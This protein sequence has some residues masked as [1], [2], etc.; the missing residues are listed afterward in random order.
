[1]VSYYWREIIEGCSVVSTSRTFQVHSEVFLL[2]YSEHVKGL[3]KDQIVKCQREWHQSKEEEEALSET[4]ASR[5]KKALWNFDYDLHDTALFRL[6]ETKFSE[7]TF[8][9]VLH[10]TLSNIQL[11]TA[12]SRNKIASEF[13]YLK[14]VS[15]FQLQ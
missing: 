9:G 11:N 6:T 13:L 1:M 8:A 2:H 7:D 15:V 12:A 4:K 3:F 5:P 14:Q 10:D